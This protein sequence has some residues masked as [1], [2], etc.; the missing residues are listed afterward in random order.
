MPAGEDADNRTS[1]WND[2]LPMR[3]ASE[4]LTSAR[5]IDSR[6]DNGIRVR[7]LWC[8]GDGRL[9][10]VVNDH[11]AGEA[12][13]VEVPPGERALDVFHHPYAYRA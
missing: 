5:E 13:S 3:M 9:F 1:A 12:F 8:E 2:R 4:P 10:V 6:S 11:G 7:L